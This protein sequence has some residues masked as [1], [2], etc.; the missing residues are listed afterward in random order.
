MKLMV[1]FMVAIVTFLLSTDIDIL[2]ERDI[3]WIFNT[4]NTLFSVGVF[5]IAVHLSQKRR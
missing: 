2:R 3:Q 1:A 4:C 5:Y